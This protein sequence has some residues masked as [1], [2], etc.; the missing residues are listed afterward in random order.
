MESKRELIFAS[1][2]DNKVKEIAAKLSDSYVVRG[3]KDIGVTE[4]IPE[5]AET[6]E[7]NASIKSQ[8]LYNKLGCDCFSDDTG[9]EVEG[10]KGE[11]GVR[12]ARYAGEDGDADKN[13][14]MLLER[15]KVVANKRARFRTVISLILDGKEHLFEGIIEGQI[16]DERRGSN[17]FG[18]DPIF[19]PNGY[20]E[21]FA[22]LPLEEKNRISHRAK[23]VDKLI[24][25]LK[26]R[27]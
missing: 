25:F 14:N 19:I 4:D 16:I 13:I 1:G 17:G 18:Y 7:G 8:Y 15:L 20:R 24:K 10:L 23:A 26:D 5:T 22:E 6:L 2:N 27:E 12:S 21:T 9:L 3:L 11:P